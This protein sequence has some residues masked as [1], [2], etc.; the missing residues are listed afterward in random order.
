MYE[1]QK[2]YLCQ[3]FKNILGTHGI[4]NFIYHRLIDHDEE[5][6]KGLTRGLWRNSNSFK[7]AWELYALSNRNEV[8]GNYSFE[9]LP[10]V[11][12]VNGYNGQFHYVS[13]RNLP[14]GFNKIKSFKILRDSRGDETKLVYECRVGGSKGSQSLISSNHNCENLFNM[15]TMGYLYNNRVENS[16]PIYRCIIPNG[17]HFISSNENCDGE[18]EGTS[19]A[20]MGYGFPM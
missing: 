11:E 8:D 7:Q 17:D 19:E 13:T 4:E 20:L 10:Y 14:S 12:M 6:R 3:A 5:I 15:G 9:L 18:G 16:I 2:Y 1:A